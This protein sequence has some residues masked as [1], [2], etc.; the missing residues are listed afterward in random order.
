MGNCDEHKRL[1]I[2]ILSLRF[3]ALYFGLSLAA[4]ARWIDIANVLVVVLCVCNEF[5]SNSGK[6]ENVVNGSQ[7]SVFD[8]T[9][10]MFVGESVTLHLYHRIESTSIPT[11]NSKQR[12]LIVI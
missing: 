7:S 12:I 8:R 11:N 1:A 5:E 4:Y 10:C 2:F 6:E 3:V 9:L